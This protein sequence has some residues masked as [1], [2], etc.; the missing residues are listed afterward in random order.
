MLKTAGMDPAKAPIAGGG[1]DKWTPVMILPASGQEAKS[2]LAKSIV[3]NVDD[4]KKRSNYLQMV[5]ALFRAITTDDFSK[6]FQGSLITYKPAHSFKYK[7]KKESLYELKQGKKDRIY[8]YPHNG[9]CGKYIFILEVLHKDQQN[10]PEEIKQH[11]EA[12]IKQI[13]D[14]NIMGPIN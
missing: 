9:K 6:F 8:L 12:S 3:A 4:G 14:T 10:T 2:Q 7:D 1:V 11:A 13:V 5:D